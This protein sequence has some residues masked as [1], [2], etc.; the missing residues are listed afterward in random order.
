VVG[1]ALYH[2]PTHR[3]RQLIVIPSH[4]NEGLGQALV[5]AVKEEAKKHTHTHTHTHPLEVHVRVG[6][7]GGEGHVHAHTH[8]HTHT[9]N[10]RGL[11]T[12]LKEKCGFVSV[13]VCEGGKSVKLQL[14]L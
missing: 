3:L 2:P 10:G 5:E 6:G 14:P 12:F 11:E 8:T 7:G 4:R 1:V 9:Q 13:G